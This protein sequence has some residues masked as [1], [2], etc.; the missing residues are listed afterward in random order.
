VNVQ[1]VFFDLGGVLLRTEYQAPRE[2]LAER[3]NMTYEDLTKIVF[4]SESSRMASVGAIT[5]EQHW[6]AVAARLGL[7]AD[8][9]EGLR[10]EFF[11]GDILDRDLIGF[12][13]ALR[14]AR[15]TGLISNAWIDM[16]GYITD[17]E[18]EDAFDA[19]VISAEVGTLK[20]GREIF[21]L[22]LT[23]L[24]VSAE[25]AVFVDDTL[26]NVEAAAAMGMHGILFRDPEDV[27]NEL[28][29]LMS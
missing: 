17:H 27:R 12:I 23:Q 29:S 9:I 3:L 15:K 26:D 13:R 5:T 20:P 25:N 21:E 24:G 16:R 6:A 11:A 8:Q 10:T 2:H 28:I 1:A 4:E 18:F 22:A 7:R 19:L 14:P